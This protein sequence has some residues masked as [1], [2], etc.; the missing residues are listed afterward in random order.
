VVPAG[1]T[2]REHVALVGR[3]DLAGRAD[4][5]VFGWGEPEQVEVAR[6]WADVK[7]GRKQLTKSV[8]RRRRVGRRFS[9]R[10]LLARDVRP[11][12]A[13]PKAQDHVGA[14]PRSSVLRRP[15]LRKASA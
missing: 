15:R 8:S 5:A 9:L 14:T 6:Y 10:G 4:S 7:A 3:A 12:E 11:V 2:R 1:L 13:L